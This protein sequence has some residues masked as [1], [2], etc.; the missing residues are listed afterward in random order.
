[1]LITKYKIVPLKIIL[2]CINLRYLGN[3]DS[4]VDRIEE[5]LKNKKIYNEELIFF[6][7]F[8]GTGA[9]SKKVSER[10]NNIIINDN[11]LLASTFTYGNL[12]GSKCTF[13]KLKLNPFDYFNSTKEI[14]KGFFYNNYAPTKSSRMYFSDFNAGRIDFFRTTIEKWYSSEMIN[15]YEY[16]YLLACL[17]ES[18]SKVANVAGVYGAYLK[19]WD[20]RALK[21]IMFLKLDERVNDKM[22][23]KRYSENLSKIVEDV[24]CDILYLDPPYTKNKYSVQYHILETLIRYDNPVLKGKTGARDMSWV[25]QS[26]STKNAVNIEFEKTVAKT[27]A[28]HIILSYSSDGLMSKEF[29]LNVLKRHCIA[30]T[31]ECIEIPYKKYR[32]YKTFTTDEHFEYLFYGKKKTENEVSYYCPLNYMGGKT[33]VIDYIKPHLNGKPILIDIMGGGFNVGINGY[34]FDKVIY[35]D[36]NYI[37]KDLVSMFKYQDTKLILDKIEKI[38]AKYSLEK[39][40]K[41]N[42]LKLREE[43]NLKYRFKQDSSIYLYTLLLYGFQQQL[44][45]NSKYEF[46]NPIGESGYNESIKEKI[47]SFSRKIKEMNVVFYSKSYEEL[48]ELVENALVYFDPP[49][50]ITLGSYN[51]G[52]RGFKGWNETEELKLINYFNR[53][54]HKNC[55]IIISNILDYKGLENKLLKEWIMLNNPIVEKMTIRGREEVLIIYEANI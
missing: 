6:D 22:N 2:G 48:E 34:G 47:I 37:V 43:Y 24:E 44:R 46:N 1:M 20:P 21:E 26:W 7:A 27:K 8:C 52:K 55:K 12:V 5:L 39:Q 31:V 35:N 18:I 13:T 19:K 40:N 17:L 41:M 29:I 45:F 14:S 16:Y 9:V 50:L 30:N 25:S 42:Y 10:F 3:K 32:N 15:E 51:D 49:Y 23:V 53:L 4:L 33:N 54:L 38:I 28:K 36:L 11:L